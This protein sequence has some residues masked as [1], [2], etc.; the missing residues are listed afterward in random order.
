[1]DRRNALKSAGVLAGSALAMPS[2]LSLLQ[3]CKN[4]PRL[5][6]QPLFFTEAEAR[7]VGALVDTILPRTD[8][9]GALDVKADLFIDTLVAKA[10]PPAGQEYFRAELERF[11]TACRAEHGEGFA[12]LDAAGRKAVLT[13]AEQESGTFNPG[14][15][16]TAVGEQ[17]P[18][19]F[20]RSFKS[21]AIWA[22]FSSEEIGEN[23]LR[24]DP[25]PGAYHGCIPA[26]EVGNRWSL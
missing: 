6:W 7:L 19:G 12:D 4:T 25:I 22:Y 26:S 18:V 21:L 17:Q 14:V 24:Y 11:D 5:E 13:R 23:V 10:Y 9:P 3:A 20:Y 2:L 15:W 1:M 8:T 16:G